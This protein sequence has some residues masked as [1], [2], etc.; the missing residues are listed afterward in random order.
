MT[1]PVTDR[2]LLRECNRITSTDA[3]M[4]I[5]TAIEAPESQ[6]L[7]FLLSEFIPL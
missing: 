7:A 1:A 5:N 2:G 4:P 6:I 3:I